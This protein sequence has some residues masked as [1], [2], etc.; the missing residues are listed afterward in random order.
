M[1]SVRAAYKAVQRPR[2]LEKELPQCALG[3]L[4]MQWLEQVCTPTWYKGLHLSCADEGLCSL[5]IAAAAATILVQHTASCS[6]EHALYWQHHCIAA[7]D[8]IAAV[9][10]CRDDAAGC[11]CCSAA[12]T[13]DIMTVVI[14]GNDLQESRQRPGHRVC[15]ISAF[16]FSGK[17]HGTCIKH[18]LLR[19]CSSA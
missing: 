8:D 2:D 1:C 17:V 9:A 10:T 14:Q 6:E 4:L 12:C 5:S 7:G 11:R 16:H 3:T 18:L 13:L 19:H 15:G